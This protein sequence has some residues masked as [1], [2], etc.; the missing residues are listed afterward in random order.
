MSVKRRTIITI[1]QKRIAVLRSQRQ[2][3]LSAFCELC[4]ARVSMLT[5]EEAAR[6]VVTT[7]R[8]MFRLVESNLVH[9]IETETGD[10]LICKKSL[11][12]LIEENGM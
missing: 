3:H 7:Q 5:V 10:L 1:E 9:S 12:S 8:K 11:K 6:F 2:K 4:C